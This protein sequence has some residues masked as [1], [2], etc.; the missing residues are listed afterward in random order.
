M[1]LCEYRLFQ[2]AQDSAVI[3]FAWFSDSHC[4]TNIGAW[5]KEKEKQGEV[6][7]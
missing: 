7:R 4:V 1:D 6:G 5:I 2:D 3:I